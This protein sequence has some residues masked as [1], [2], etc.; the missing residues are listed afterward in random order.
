MSTTARPDCCPLCCA[1]PWRPFYVSPG[2]ESVVGW[3][4]CRACKARWL[5]AWLLSALGEAAAA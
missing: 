1:G 3:Y 4:R 2:A 5:C